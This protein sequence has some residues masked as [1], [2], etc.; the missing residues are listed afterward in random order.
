V[1]SQADVIKL[2]E[3]RYAAMLAGDV[4]ALREIFAEDAVYT[5]SNGIAD[6]KQAYLKA[7]TS[8]EFIYRT[9]ERFDEQV[10]IL[11]RGALVTGRIRLL[12]DFKAGPKV[13]ESRFPQSMGAKRREMAAPGLAIDT[14]RQTL[15]RPARSDSPARRCK[16]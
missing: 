10:K 3:R 16:H 1:I 2:E 15:K 12:V 6:D 11:D 14:A 5:H 7:L 4:A 13:L 8:G 9:I